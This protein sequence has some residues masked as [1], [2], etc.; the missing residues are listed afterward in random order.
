MT[1]LAWI[2][3][4]VAL[5]RLHV[6]HAEATDEALQDSSESDWQESE[7]GSDDELSDW[8]NSVAAEDDYIAMCQAQVPSGG[9]PKA[10]LPAVKR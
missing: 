3:I 9:C 7:P 6:T 8:S 10:T 1:S 5:K 2:K 4:C